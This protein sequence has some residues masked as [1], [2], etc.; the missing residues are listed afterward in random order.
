M[1]RP[2]WG[3]DSR[4]EQLP[5][6]GDQPA[7]KGRYKLPTLGPQMKNEGFQPPNG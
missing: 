3:S 2:F 1:F 7:V 4:T 6:G 5:F